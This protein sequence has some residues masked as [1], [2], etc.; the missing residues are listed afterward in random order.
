MSTPVDGPVK[1]RIKPEPELEAWLVTE[2][3]CQK[4]AEWA[5]SEAAI[6]DPEARCVV[7]T[8]RGHCE[9]FPGGGAVRITM[10]P[11]RILPGEYVIRG[12]TG[13][14]FRRTAHE[15]HHSYQVIAA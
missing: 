5:G 1:C 8:G 13:D 4:I 7:L 11:T 10:P 12:V 15:F 2:D 3:N 6:A 14:F 9:Q